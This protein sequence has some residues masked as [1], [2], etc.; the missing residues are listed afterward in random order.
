MPPILQVDLQQILSQA[1]TFVL[2]VVV[3]KRVAWKPVLGL[4]DARRAKIEGDL[5]DAERI[6]AEMTALQQD[7]AQR[8]ATI[9]EEARAKIQQSIQDGRRI[10]S[11]IQDEARAQAQAV[12]AKSQ[13]TIQLELAKAKVGLRNELA[14]LTTEAVHRLLKEKVTSAH[15]EKLIG[16]ILDE[17]TQPTKA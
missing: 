7:Y 15:D 10:A 12:L 5:R 8:L 4:L 13:E 14:D 2:L 3:L 9:D 17:L 6:K 11:E 1:V 16:S